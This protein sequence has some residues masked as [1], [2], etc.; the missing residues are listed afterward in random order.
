M[1][2][3]GVAIAKRDAWKKELE[4]IYNLYLNH[5]YLI[6]N[7]QG[8]FIVKMQTS[9]ASER[10]AHSMSAATWIGTKRSEVFGNT[11]G[12]YEERVQTGGVWS[13][14]SDERGGNQGELMAPRPPSYTDFVSTYVKS[15][16]DIAELTKKVCVEIRTPNANN[17]TSI[18]RCQSM[19]TWGVFVYLCTCTCMQ[20]QS[21]EQEIQQWKYVRPCLCVC[22][23]VCLCCVC[24]SVCMCTCQLIVACTC[25]NMNQW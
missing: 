2:E 25:R 12:N 9:G 21:L 14:E 15:Q 11:D 3:R 19:L 22:L 23:C 6:F 16:V 18:G 1:Q 5:V 10:K 20:V 8:G 4:V 24:I 13:V 17:Y 7:V